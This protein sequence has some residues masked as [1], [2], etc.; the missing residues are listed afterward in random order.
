M[1]S[2][3]DR[4][5]QWREPARCRWHPPSG[6]SETQ[7]S[8]SLQRCRERLVAKDRMEWMSL[9]NCESEKNPKLRQVG[10]LQRVNRMFFGN[11]SE[12]KHVDGR[13][14]C[15]VNDFLARRYALP[16]TNLPLLPSLATPN[17]RPAPGEAFAPGEASMECSDLSELWILPVG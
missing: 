4:S 7:S 12:T 8:T 17:I 6:T 14:C 3:S 16:Q 10:A 1:P 5:R 13:G 2:R 15:P 9:E 11:R